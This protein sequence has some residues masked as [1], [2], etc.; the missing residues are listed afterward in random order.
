MIRPSPVGLA[1]SAVFLVADLAWLA[2]ARPPG[3]ELLLSWFGLLLLAGA[4]VPGAAN[5]VTLA[6][7]HLTAPAL[8]Y[9]VDPSRLLQ[10]AA[11]V[12]LAGLSD[13]IDGA[14]ARRFEGPSRLGGALDPVIDG[15]FFGA[16]AIGLVIGVSYPLWLAGAVVLRYALPAVAGGLLLLAGRRP[17]LQHTPLGQASTTLIGILLGGAALLHGLGWGTGGLLLMLSEVIIPLAAVATFGNLFWANRRA[18]LGR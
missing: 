8:V 13:V 11:V 6:R 10:L 17:A 18:L 16:V 2:L 3:L 12:T 1:G 4:L 9:S 5:Q 14:V 7:A 15:L